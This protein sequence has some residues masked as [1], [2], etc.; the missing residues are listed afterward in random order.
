MKGLEGKQHYGGSPKISPG[1][2]TL[3]LQSTGYIRLILPI[4]LTFIRPSN[5]SHR[6]GHGQVASP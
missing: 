6:L 4:N 1:P 3:R 5:G 2:L